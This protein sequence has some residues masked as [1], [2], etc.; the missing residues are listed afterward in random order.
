MTMRGYSVVSV[1]CLCTDVH[2]W[3]AKFD[4]PRKKNKKKTQFPLSFLIRKQGLVTLIITLI[5][6]TDKH[7]KWQVMYVVA[8]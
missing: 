3:L 2:F 1:N 5:A 8:N 7:H 4:E 6:Q